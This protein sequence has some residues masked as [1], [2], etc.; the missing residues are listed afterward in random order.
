MKKLYAIKIQA[1]RNLIQLVLLTVMLLGASLFSYSQ[2]RVPFTPRASQYTPGQTVY[3][4]KGDFT[5]VGNTNLTLVNY[6]TTRNN[7]NNDMEFVDVDGDSSTNNSS[8]STLQF[9]EE[10]GAIQSCSNIIY[11]GLYWTGRSNSS[12]FTDLQRRTIKFKGPNQSYQTLVAEAGDIRYPGDNGMYAGYKEVTAEVINGGIGEYFV[13]DMALSEGDGG[14]T[15]YYG[16]WGMVVVYENSKMDWRDVTVFDGYAYVTGGNASHTLDISGFKSVQNG[17]V[18]FKLGMMAGEGDVGISGD[19]FQIRRQSDNQYQSLS[20][21]GNTATNFFNSSISTGGNDRDLELQNNTGL[22]IA[23]F[24]VANPNNTIITNNQTSTRFRYGSTADTYIIFNI[25]FS[26]DAYVPDVEGTVTTTNVNNM[27]NPVPLEVVPGDT[28]EYG[29]EIRNKGTE[30]TNNTVITLPIPYTSSYNDLSIAYTVNPPLFSPPVPAPYYNPNLGATGSIVWEIGT[31]PVPTNPNDILAT[32][33][34]EL[35][36]TTD[37]ALLVN[38]S[39]GT[40]ISLGGSISGVGNTS[41][42]SFNQNLIQGFNATGNCIGEPIPTPYIIPINSQQYV[43]EN[44]GSYTAVRDFYF[45]NIGTTPIQTS[46][47][48]AEFPQGSRYYNEYPLT[49]TTT[50]YNASNPFPPVTG[51]YYAIP[52]GSSTCYYQFTIHVEVITSTPTATDVFYCLNETASPLTATPSAQGNLLF[53]Y[54]NNNPN[55][56]GQT[57]IT[58]STTAAGSTTYY[59]AEGLDEDCVSPNRIPIV[60]TVYDEI[61]ITLESITP[62]TCNVNN[63]G[64]I[65]ISVTGGTGDYTYLWNDTANSTT[66]DISGLAA[67]SYTVVINDD[68]SNCTATATFEVIVEAST[69]PIITAPVGF[70]TDGCTSADVTNGDLT[71]LAYSETE[72]TITEAEF[73]AEG[74]TF[75]ENNVASITY[76]DSTSGSCPLLVTRTFTI[77]NE[78]DVSTNDTQTITINSPA[79]V[80]NA[81]ANASA[82]ACDYATQ[83]EVDTAFNTWLE[84]FTVSG[85]CDATGT[86][87]TP[88]APLLCEGGTTTVTYTITDACSPS[89]ID[90]T[91]SITA[92]EALVVNAPDNASAEACDYATQAEVDTAFNTWLEGFT[93]SGGCDASGSYGTPTAPLLCEGGTT[94]VTYTITDA[95]S[96]STMD[97]TFS[98]TAP[99]ALVVNAPANASAEA[100]DYATQAEVDT[101]FNLWLEGFTVSGGCDASGSYGT[102]T[103]PLLCEGGTTTVTYT[104]TDACSP[105]TIER[106]FSITAPEALVVNAPANASAEACDYA[107]QAEVET[108]FNLWLEGF[109]VSGGC[110]ATGTYGTPTAPVLCEGGTTTVTYTITDACSPTT[111]ERTFSITAPEALVVNA[112]DNA[113]AEACDY[114]TQAE[115]DTAFNTWL[116][117]FTVSGGCDATGTYGTPTAPVLCEGGSTTVTYTITDACSPSTIERTFSIAT[118]TPL[119]IVTEASNIDIQCDGTGNNGAIQEWLDNNG[120]AVISDNCSAITWTNNYG[121]AASD[122]AAPIFVTFTATDACGNSV[123]T[124]ASYSIIDAV[125]PE[126]TT[127]ASPLTVECDGNGNMDDLNSWLTSNGG[128][129]ATDDC[130]AI[131]WT[132][133]YTTL[134]DDCGETGSA[135]VTFTATDACGNE[136]F[137]TAI[138]T[139]ID[140]IA[141]VA[142]TAPAPLAYQCLTDVTVADELTATDNCSG[143]IIGV[144]EEITDNSNP[145]NII[146][147]RT[148]TFTDACDNSSSVSQ[149]ITVSDTI[150]PVAPEAPA[151]ITVEC[152]VSDL[153]VPPVLVALDNCSGEI[154]GV[155]EE[156]IDNSNS[157]NVIITRTWTFTDACNNSSSVSQ[158]IIEVDTIAPVAPDAPADISYECIS[159]VPLAAELTANDACAGS[160]MGVVS[161]ITDE[162]NPCNI[163]IT[164]TWTFTDSCNNSSTVS[165]TITVADTIA[166]VIS[167]EASNIDI[168]C[169]GTGNDGAIVEWLNN[170]GGA[171]ASDN[172]GTITW[173]NNYGGTASDCAAPI[174]ITFTATDAC[175]NFV[176]TSA[177]YSIID[178]VAPQITV[179]TSETV[180]CDGS[181]NTVA[182]EAWLMN[183]GG[184]TAT[185]DCSAITWSNNFTSITNDCGETGSASVTFTATD[186]CGNESS[187]TAIF[188]IIDTI[189]PVAPTA[190]AYITY[191]CVADVPVAVQ[192]TA[193]DNCAGEIVGVLEEITDNSDSC[194]ITITRTWTFTDPCNN[195]SSVSQII[196]VSDTTPPTFNGVNNPV[197]VAE[198]IN[199]SFEANTFNG[200]HVQFPQAQVP[201][202]STTA[203]HGTLE[204]QRNGQVDGSVPHSGNYH[205][206]LNGR[207]LDDLY[208]EF[209]TLPSSELEIT[210]FHKKR[211]GSSV[212]D[213]L[214]LYAGNDLNNLTLLGTFQVNANEGWKENIV[215]YTVPANHNSTII[216]FQAIS[217][218]TVSVGNLLDDIS[219]SS[220][221]N[222][223]GPMPLDITVECTEIPEVPILTASDN[224]GEATVTFTETQNPGSCDN[225]YTIIRTWTATDTCGNSI[226]HTQ[227]ITVQDTTAPGFVQSP[228][229]DITVECDEIPEAPVLTATDN[230][231]EATVAFVE[232]ST[233]GDCPTIEIIERTWTA[234]DAC[235]NETIITQVITVV[236]TLA[237]TAPDAPADITYECVADVPAPGE[238]TATDNCS[239]DITIIGIDVTDSTDPC[240]VIITRT[241][242]FT[243][244]CN[245]TSSVTQTITVSDTTPP[246]FTGVNEPV[247]VAEIING[248]FEANT[249]NG[250]HVQFPHEEVPGWSTTAA[251]GTLEIQRNGQID[252]SIP[253][254][255]NYHF[256]L[257]GRGLD[258]LY[259]EFC[260][261]P[262]SELEI[263]FYH[264]KRPGSSVVDVLELYAGNDLNNLTLLGTFQ[265][266]EQEDWKENIVNYTVPANH[267]STIILFQAVSGSSSSVGNLLDD[268]SV[269]SNNNSYGP[270]PT[271]ITVECTDIPEIPEL[272]ATDNCGDASVTFTETQ[273]PGACDNEYTIVRTW[274]ASDTCGNSISHVQNIT[275]QDTTAPGFVQ[276]PPQN[277]TVECD[278]IPNAPIL[279]ATD[280]CGDATVTFIESSTTGTCPTLEIIE[281]TWTATDACGN[282]TIITQVITVVDTIAPVAPAAPADITLEC[283]IS[284]IPDAVELTAVDSCSGDIIGIVSE[285]TD[286]SNPCNVT[287]TRTWTFT[288]TCNNSSTVS[289]TIT[290]ADTIAPLAPT[291]PADITYECVAD[292]PVAADL[293][294]TD[295]C[296]GEITGVVSE[297]MDDSN[298]CNVIIIRT[299]TFTDA[300]NNSSSVSQTIS[301]SDTIAPLAPTAPADITYEC[302]ADV[303]VAA[304]LIAIDNCAGDITGVVS[305]TMDDSNACNVIIIRTWTFTDACNNSS[306]V[307]QTITVADTTAPTVTNNLSDITVNCDVIPDV[308]TL[309]F[310]DC[311]SNVTI[312]YFNEDN[313]F[314]GTNN[315]YEIIW[316]WEFS[317]TCGNIGTA[318]Q[319]VYVTMT[320]NV[321]LVDDNRCSDDGTIDLFDYYNGT[322]TSGT[323]VVISGQTSLDGS[324][325]D[326]SDVPLGNYEFSYTVA[327][328]GCLSTTEVTITVND[329]C[330]VL[331][332]GS[333]DVIISKAITPNGDQWNEYF[334]VTGIETCGFVIDVKIFNRWGAM[335]YESGDYQN[336]WNGT[337]SKASIGNANNVPA[338]TYY[339]ILNLKNSGLQPITGYVYIGTK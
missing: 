200:T 234:T 312:T 304:D 258:D 176:N 116:E 93:V 4:I 318:S 10:N 180:E 8:S 190:P 246:E 43:T 170:N 53:Y 187:T 212:V 188:T 168:Q 153:P 331:P 277:I 121:G 305:E 289:Q 49:P 222:S 85:G 113:S 209:C 166:P 272:T 269:S 294:A 150:A 244:V 260:T 96:P 118:P 228:P 86:Y 73:L 161:E 230:C 11:A 40:N 202:W 55:T 206:E 330:I 29:M 66:Q 217:G 280:N 147:T 146:I 119:T 233:M 67:G 210:F 122:C 196:I 307:S 299:W 306:S 156:V 232:S 60:V 82:E 216:L 273:T 240:N 301:I 63:I 38:A 59:V 115:V 186:G 50:E 39:C 92:P 165:Q 211:A 158:I 282:E 57:S 136:S 333:D 173:T 1:N 137:T 185:D 291:A 22:D 192:L 252:G 80:V 135:S 316:T 74:G 99:E 81:P 15:G 315:N 131:S 324:Y 219:V 65:D 339:Y 76:Q 42:T 292:V 255:G 98:I 189:A 51:T 78:C 334:T 242:T 259:Q 194:N 2:V 287:I 145:C 149:I 218:S 132:N 101:A 195:S 171:S 286:E 17:D 128:A 83:A 140:S 143:D 64:A 138:F 227:N 271:D 270:L 205:F 139:I 284:D 204:L 37:C 87:G 296:A 36:A 213:V 226:S 179:A 225:E 142:P 300:C 90:R 309:E 77:T 100:C 75:T 177:S 107:T 34:F 48:S 203:P 28:V 133:N 215:N 251:H 21:T 104:I 89:T 223:Y 191:E 243:D 16:G 265:V 52:P 221:N 235:G 123:N 154:I 3:N 114:A 126:I 207:G 201:G 95:C 184:A 97:R 164:R 155:L 19:Y 290:V 23:M 237:P 208:Q 46:Q 7:S 224:C 174:L 241:W 183:N 276:N 288:D 298:S 325:F 329:D 33:S 25:T 321:Q 160:I 110:D 313:S 13:A 283:V 317:D 35:V 102:P 336:N 62:T 108:A 163:L 245:N 181:G 263:T 262:S 220:N 106:T 120:Y 327:S 275:V 332:C 157:C 103:A 274:T 20:H 148:W 328:N 175:G 32:L 310:D 198:L 264:K 297:T 44:C 12:N 261:L 91:F 199:G 125:D 124:S 169:D 167:V 18:D 134:S 256:E 109:T 236:D 84:G 322:D 162:T 266:N 54:I 129:T 94:T 279:T 182:L 144:L 323:W 249:F 79:V 71:A 68:N 111:L 127:P 303:P 69:T 9:S 41:Q 117:G 24:E 14:S 27:P 152:I 338:G 88:T 130:S 238:L 6:N 250:E 61:T 337:V 30:A 58:P 112:P 56:I 229:Q 285:T 141:P 70:S 254:S 151:N 105:S 47:V 231:G 278:A 281:R 26:V 248:T 308:P 311:S 72:V 268:I 214:E 320:D 31:L 178:N 267:N 172:C 247:C 5:M 326:P 193:T 335:I 319:I 197:C 239:G 45:C 295:N 257:N 253:H 302:V 314:D 159:E 293:I